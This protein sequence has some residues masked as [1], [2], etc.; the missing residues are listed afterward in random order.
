MKYKLGVAVLVTTGLI[1]NSQQKNNV[2]SDSFITYHVEAELE[3]DPVVSFDDAAD[4]V[5]IWE[6]KINPSKSLVVG[7]DKDYGLIVYDLKGKE[8]KSIS[9]WKDQQC[10]L[11]DS[12]SV[13]QN[14]YP[15]VC[16]QIEPMRP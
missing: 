9:S 16:A 6:N 14:S 12:P 4:D 15:I 1:A 2:Y 8:L 13:L 3:T 7:T 5:C 11:F 10:C